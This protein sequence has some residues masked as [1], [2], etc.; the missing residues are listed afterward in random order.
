MDMD[1]TFSACWY[2]SGP[3]ASGKTGVVLELA[4]RMNAEILSLDSMA[5]YQGMDIGTATPT[6]EEQA[7]IPHHMLNLIPPAEEYS[8]ARY[9][10]AAQAKIT[11]IHAREKRVLFV[12]GTPLFL[13]SL[14][15]GIFEG[16]EADW[17]FRHQVEEEIKRVG[18]EVLH[19]RLK[20]IDPLSAAKLHPNDT[21]RLIRALEV[22]KL[23]GQPISHMQMQF[24]EGQTAE[25][26]R[27]FVLQR[28]IEELHERIDRRVEGM[29]QAG[30]VEEVQQ[31]LERGEAFS[32]TA[33]HAV[34]YREVLA[35]L[36]GECSL[37]EAKEQMKTR[38]RRFAKRQRTWFRSLSECRMI[39]VTE[40][41]TDEAIADKIYEQ[42]MLVRS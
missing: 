5:I 9:L 19:E 28:T 23:T 33:K 14:L 40:E 22:H 13:K 12:G 20:Q 24:D 7:E 8:V 27:V 32:R 11:E 41:E 42:G 25:E 35:Y 34:G 16:P 36:A 4:R 15:R 31:L 37:E 39:P 6:S 1:E 29:I 21:R 10:E 26:C 2:L 17:E 30:L 38:T 3:T 18:H